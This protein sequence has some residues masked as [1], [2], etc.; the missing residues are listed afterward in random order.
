MN[1]IFGKY[2]PLKLII[3]TIAY[4][5]IAS[6]TSLIM[7]DKRPPP[8]FQNSCKKLF[9]IDPE[10][11]RSRDSHYFGYRFF[12]NHEFILFFL[13]EKFYFFYDKNKNTPCVPSL[14]PDEKKI[15]LLRDRSCVRFPRTNCFF[16]FQQ[17]NILRLNLNFS[18]SY[19]RLTDFKFF[20]GLI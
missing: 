11:L 1:L 7:R 16:I 18:T 4:R 2:S 19:G 10:W 9:H 5:W 20:L 3:Y 12:S 17:E 15:M 13:C 8:D 14:W 6:L